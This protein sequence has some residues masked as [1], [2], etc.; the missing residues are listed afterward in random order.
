MADVRLSPVA[1]LAVFRALLAALAQ[2]GRVVPNP[3][4]APPGTTPALLQLLALADLE[5]AHR[6]L[7]LAASSGC[8]AAGRARCSAT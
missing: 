7:A 5:V 2:P 1:S 4:A 3:T 6:L 8:P